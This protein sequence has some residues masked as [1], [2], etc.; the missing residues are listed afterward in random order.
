MAGPRV[1]VPARVRG[2]VL[3]RPVAF[4]LAGILLAAGVLALDGLLGPRAL[5]PWL[6]FDADGARMLYATLAGALLT[7]AGIT[8]WVRSATVTLAAGQYSANVVMGFLEDWFQQS[9]MSLMLGLFAFVVTVYRALPATPQGAMPHLAVLLGI[10]L[11]ASSVVFVM[12]AIRNGVQSMYPGALGRKI[13]D[14]TVERIRATLPVVAGEPQDVRIAPPSTP[15]IRVRAGTSGWV[16]VIDEAGLLEA[17]PPGAVVQLDVRVGLYAVEGRPLAQVWDA[18]MDEAAVERH[19]R[20]TIRIGRR[21]LAD[22]IEFGVQQLVDLAVGSLVGSAA[23][24]TSAFEVVQ[25]LELVLWE[26]GRR[27]LRPRASVDDRDRTLIRARHITYDDYVRIAFDRLRRTSVTYPTVSGA[28]IVTASEV[29][30]DL[31]DAGFRGR[32]AILR[33]HVELILAAADRP[34]VLDSDR[35]E[36]ERLARWPRG[37]RSPV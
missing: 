3:L 25:H 23:D 14:A 26:L 24:V 15:S 8:F 29:A 6:R 13:S 12:A 11:A 17:L 28:M 22:D 2:S 9:I 10:A 35:R 5:P 36:L 4:V 20:S 16:A 19:V 18:G 34:D 27:A 1:Q 30:R 21:S 32:A 33:Q 37:T 7:V 31:D